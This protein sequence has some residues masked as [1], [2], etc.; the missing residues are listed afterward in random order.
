MV[1]IGTNFIVYLWIVQST[2]AHYS[3]TLGIHLFMALYGLSV[4]L[5]TPKPLRKGRKR[6]IAVSFAITALAALSASLEMARYFQVLFNST[7]PSHWR[8]LMQ[9]DGDNWKYLVGDTSIAFIILIG[10]ALLVSAVIC[11]LPVLFQGSQ[12][13][14]RRCIG[15]TSSAWNIGGS[16]LSPFLRRCRR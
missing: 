10:D 1:E 9:A 14:Y 3:L 12:I 11:S 8:E 7:S 15:V 6:Y 16:Q 4:F 13:D 5:E 2:S